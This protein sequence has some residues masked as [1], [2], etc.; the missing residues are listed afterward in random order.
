MVLGGPRVGRPLLQHARSVPERGCEVARKIGLHVGDALELRRKFESLP[1]QREV[2]GVGDARREVAA[3]G[4]VVVVDLVVVVEI[5]VAD[6]PGLHAAADGHRIGDLLV[7]VV[8][9]VGLVEIPRVDGFALADDVEG[10][11][12]LLPVEVDDDVLVVAEVA[13]EAVM[14]I[15]DRAPPLEV[16]LDAVVGHH[17]DV[18]LR[19]VQVADLRRN[20]HVAQDA[21]GA[22]LIEVDAEQQAVVRR[23]RNPVRGCRCGWSPTRCS[24]RRNP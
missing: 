3:D 16:Q 9:A 20:L 11:D 21:F 15:L 22:F 10:L 8:E 2:E 1:S 12:V 14:E 24:R 19:A 6:V 23:P 4:A 13:A 17:A 5:L 18:L 7:T